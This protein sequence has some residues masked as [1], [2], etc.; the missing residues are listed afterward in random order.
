MSGLPKH[1]EDVVKRIRSKLSL[2]PVLAMVMA[3]FPLASLAPALAAPATGVFISELHYDNA[4]SDV[5]EFV[6]VTGDAGGDLTDWSVELYNGNGG[7]S[8]GTIA[9]SGVVD[10]ED[11]SQGAVAFFHAGIQNGSPDGLAL[12]NPGGVVIEFLS[13][14]GSF[15]AV[16]GPA[17]G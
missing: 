5:G 4:S 1:L 13:Y 11:G 10:D 8:Y 12:V 14:E 17:D 7:A 16:G 3:L 2:L 6:E 15:V 9:L